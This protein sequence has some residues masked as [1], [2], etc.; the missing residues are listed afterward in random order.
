MASDKT[1]MILQQMVSAEQSEEFQKSALKSLLQ[2]P[3]FSPVFSK[4]LAT[5]SKE[6]VS[7]GELADW[8]ERDSIIAGQ[9]LRTVNSAAYGCRGTIGSVRHAI[10]ILGIPKLRNLVLGL[11]VSRIFSQ[12]RTPKTWS[13]SR[14]N[15]HAAACAIMADQMALHKAVEFGEGAFVA[16]LLH[17]IGRM[18]IALGLPQELVR[19]QELERESA[20]P[21]WQC[22]QEVLG[23]SHGELSGIILKRWNLPRPIQLAAETH[24]F[25]PSQLH[26]LVPLGQIVGLANNLVNRMGVSIEATR[27]PPEDVTPFLQE[28]G[29]GDVSEKILKTF[30]AEFDAMRSAF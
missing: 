6:D 13:T 20:M 3:P 9:L 7:V 22:E 8:V 24:H 26:G 10:A 30:V 29:W 14:Y 4:L 18:V 1:R 19:I 25:P 15:L 28:Q 17:D 11:S 2:L 5:L 21:G 16:G 23:F 27:N 12:V